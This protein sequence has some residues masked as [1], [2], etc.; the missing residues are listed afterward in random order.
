VSSLIQPTCPP[1]AS[2]YCTLADP[3]FDNNVIGDNEG[4][5]SLDSLFLDFQFNEGE[6]VAEYFN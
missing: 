3:E 5:L 6:T 4:F 1:R 2:I